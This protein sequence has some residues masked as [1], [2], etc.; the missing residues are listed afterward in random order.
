[1][2]QSAGLCSIRPLEQKWKR[3]MIPTVWRLLDRSVLMLGRRAICISGHEKV[4]LTQFRLMD[5]MTGGM[6][7]TKKCWRS[8]PLRR[9]LL[10]DPKILWKTGIASSVWFVEGMCKWN[11]GVY[12]NS[13]DTF[14]GSVI[15]GQI[16]GFVPVI[17]LQ[18]YVGW[19]GV[20]FMVQSWRLRRSCSF[21]WRCQN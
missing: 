21:I 19:M 18:R 2:F 11:L 16:R 10:R 1:M 8:P 5:Q 12:M 20:R 7:L 17:I 9:Y 14:S 3:S 13:G 15:W 4:G 6:C